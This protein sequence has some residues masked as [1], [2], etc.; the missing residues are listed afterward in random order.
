MWMNEEFKGTLLDNFFLPCVQ[1][2]FCSLY[3]L[4]VTFTSTTMAKKNNMTIFLIQM[5]NTFL[6]EGNSHQST[7]Q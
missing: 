5:E 3:F 7:A 4:H 6:V 2:R 1:K